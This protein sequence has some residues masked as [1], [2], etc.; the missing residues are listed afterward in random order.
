LQW[1][2]ASETN[3]QGFEVEHS[4]DN[5]TWKT[6]GFVSGEGTTYEKQ[7][8]SFLHQKPG[9]GVNYYRLKQMDYDGVFEYSDVV[10]VQLAVD[11]KQLVVAPNPVQNGEVSLFFAESEDENNTLKIFNSMG[12]LVRS[13]QL[14]YNQTTIRVDD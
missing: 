6:L 12:V 3:N 14:G 5:R 2:T 9:R 7:T 13:A 4:L 11:S 10:S 8:Y 1:Q